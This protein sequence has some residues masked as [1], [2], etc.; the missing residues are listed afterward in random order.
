[1]RNKDGK[2]LPGRVFVGF[3][4]T[5]DPELMT[6]KFGRLYIPVSSKEKQKA[7]WLRSHSLLN[8]NGE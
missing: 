7:S 1:M 4:P 3:V 8:N 6:L 5:Y 2:L